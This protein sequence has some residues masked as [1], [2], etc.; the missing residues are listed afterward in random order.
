MTKHA[1]KPLYSGTVW[2]VLNPDFRKICLSDI[3][4]PLSRIVR[5]DGQS[6]VAV[7]LL[8]HSL[9]VEY[10][11]VEEA[12]PYALLHDVHEVFLGD[13]TVPTKQALAFECPEAIV[14]WKEITRWHDEAIWEAF[15]LEN[16]GDEILAE[17][18]KADLWALSTEREYY[19]PKTD[20]EWVEMPA[21][22]R[23]KPSFSIGDHIE[24][25]QLFLHRATALCPRYPPL[26]LEERE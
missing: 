18:K 25:R 2:D 5:Y 24:N 4:F 26:I 12:K 9:M 20:C 8:W 16:P 7:D 13:M 21:P 23:M 14:A 1:Y 10:L 6:T 22:F 15:G 17:V 3:I 11:A 19:L